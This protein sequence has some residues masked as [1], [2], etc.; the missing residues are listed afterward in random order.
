MS[1]QKSCAFFDLDGTLLKGFIIQAFPQYLANNGYIEPIYSRK[2]DK[3][4]SDYS[5][6]RTT[7]REAAEIVPKI[8]ASALKGK[9]LD[10]VKIFSK[11][12][13]K[14]YLPEHVFPY[15][16][17][18][19]QKIGNLVDYKIAIS[20]SPNDVIQEFKPLGFDGIY[21]SIFENQDD[22]FTGNVVANLILGEEKYKLTINICNEWNI[23]LSQSLAFGDTD[24]DVPLLS[25][26]DLPIAINPNKKLLEICEMKGWKWFKPMEIKDL[27]L[28][29]D[30]IKNRQ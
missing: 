4:A 7:Y 26:V 15:T 16:K 24:Q 8:Y 10:D 22:I 11:R 9:N 5:S 13:M 17:Q 14:T 23:D 19:I 21:G 2:I 29:I 6:G 12:F 28:L 27:D 1:L 3:I 18:L 30:W 25:S 20:G